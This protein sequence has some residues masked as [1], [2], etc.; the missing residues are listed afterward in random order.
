MVNDII[1]NINKAILRL[2]SLQRRN[3]G[4]RVSIKEVSDRSRFVS[5][6]C[7]IVLIRKRQWN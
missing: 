3:P 7:E 4:A 2:K 5:N 1:M 6:P